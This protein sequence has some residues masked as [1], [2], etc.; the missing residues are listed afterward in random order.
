MV[1]LLLSPFAKA[2]NVLELKNVESDNLDLTIEQVGANNTI[3]MGSRC[4]FK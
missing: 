3:P 2:D 1:S 4:F